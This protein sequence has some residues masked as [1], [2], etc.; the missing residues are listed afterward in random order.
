MNKFID[1]QVEK[2]HKHFRKLDWDY[3]YIGSKNDLREAL[4]E[5]YNKDSIQTVGA[6]QIAI[7]KARSEG[8]E[9]GRE[10]EKLKQEGVEKCAECGEYINGGTMFSDHKFV[11]NKCCESKIR[12][13]KV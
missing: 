2:W 10:D 1:E 9:Q 13:L 7:D 11:C 12:G 3:D 4:T 8:Y 6:L 5:A